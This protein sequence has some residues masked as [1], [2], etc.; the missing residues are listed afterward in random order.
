MIKLTVITRSDLTKAQK[1]I[2]GRMLNCM[3]DMSG[4]FC[5]PMDEMR[6][7]VDLLK[8]FVMFVAAD[9]EMPDVATYQKMNV[10]GYGG[11]HS[12]NMSGRKAKS[13]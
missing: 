3:G 13:E 7:C 1:F 4:G 9:E 11:S 2:E 5:Q 10:T 6:G 12:Q 8:S